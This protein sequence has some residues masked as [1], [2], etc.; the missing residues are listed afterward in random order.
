LMLLTQRLAWAQMSISPKLLPIL[1][2][3]TINTD[4]VGILD[5]L[6][7]KALDR[8]IVWHFLRQYAFRSQFFRWVR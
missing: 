1:P 3:Q 5:P 6:L 4:L 7:N 2:R 8:R